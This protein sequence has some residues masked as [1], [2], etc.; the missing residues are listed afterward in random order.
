MTDNFLQNQYKMPSYINPDGSFAN[1]HVA[2]LACRDNMIESSKAFLR[3]NRTWKIIEDCRKILQGDDK[4]LNNLSRDFKIEISKLRRQGRE[5]IYNVTNIKPGFEVRTAS[6]NEKA[7]KESNMYDKLKE[8][9]WYSRNVN[10]II[11]EA[12]TEA[13]S[14]IGHLF[15]W[16]KRDPNTNTWE[17]TPEAKNYKEVFPYQIPADNDLDK[18]YSITVWCEVPYAQFCEEYPEWAHTVM[19]DRTAP[20]Y[21][22]KTFNRAKQYASGIADVIRRKRNEKIESLGEPSFPMVDLFYTFTR[23]N[24]INTSGKDI[25][26]GTLLFSE[27]G[28]PELA[29]HDSYKVQSYTPDKNIEDCKLFPYGRRLTVTTNTHVLNDG[30]PK[31]LCDCVPVVDLW[32]ERLPKEYIGVPVLND[33]RS[34]E[35]AINKMINSI[36][37]RINGAAEMPL[38]IADDLPKAV[39][40]RIEARGIKGLIG[41]AIRMNFRLPQNPIKALFDANLFQIKKEE[42]EVIKALQDLQEYIVGTN[43]QS[44]LARLGQ[45]PAADTQEALAASQGVLSQSH[46]EEISKGLMKF[47]HIWLQLAPQVYTLEKRISIL[48]PDGIKLEDVMDYEPTSIIPSLD[49][50]SQGVAYWKRLRNHLK[51]FRLFGR[52]TSFQER[53]SVTNKLVLLQVQKAGGTISDRKIYDK[54]IG[55]GKY[56]E[57]LEEWKKEQQMKAELAAAIRVQVEGIQQA[58]GVGVSPEVMGI[59]RGMGLMNQQSTLGQGQPS[60]NETLPRLEMK[61]DQDGVPR[62]TNATYSN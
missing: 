53:Q 21:L 7:Q 47:A 26:M 32:F 55:D 60:S 20:T 17:I 56:E 24:T 22:G 16:P 51:Q 37:D 14:G 61:H 44:N 41:R 23:D 4:L 18:A 39:L 33:G 42:F 35:N 31:W 46:D 12:T 34:L 45:M 29:G 38:A 58:G 36:K 6:S 49:P 25:M 3:A 48:G 28:E 10:S 13:A 57:T 50:I 54:F 15:V 59:L 8:D 52:A 2:I 19:P 30:A 5:I 1:N 27:S 62:S 9:W 40:A 43:D 11:E